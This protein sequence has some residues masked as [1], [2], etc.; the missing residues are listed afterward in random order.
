MSL[1]SKIDTLTAAIVAL[2]AAIQAQQPTG[3]ASVPQSAPVVQPP[4]PAQQAA[5]AMPPA[6]TF[7]TPPVAAPAATPV[8]TAVPFTDVQ[9]LFKYTAEAYQAIE[10][11]TPGRGAEIQTRVMAA[12][13]VGNVN[14]IKPEQYANFYAGVEAIKA[15][16]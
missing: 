13:G 15:G 16:K 2:T 3:E 5:P 8:T 10:A 14:D 9:G 12:L 11:A 6:P 1:E 7:M 4:A